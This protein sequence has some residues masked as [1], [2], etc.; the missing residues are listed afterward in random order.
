MRITVVGCGHVGLITGTCL[1]S[2]GHHVD[3]VDRD[4]YRIGQLQSGCLPLSEPHLEEIFQHSLAAGQIAFC[5]DMSEAFTQADIIFLCVGVPQL[6]NGESDFAALDSAAR[7]IAAAVH[8]PKLVVVRSTVPVQTTLQLQ[9]LLS[10]YHGISAI[11]FPVACNPQF[12]RQ[13][14]AVSGFFHPDRLLLGVEDAQSEKLLREIYRSIL[15]RRFTCPVHSGNCPASPPPELLV[16]KVRSAE[17]IKQTSNAYLAVKISYANVLADLCE[18]LGGNVAEVTHA[19]GLDPRIGSQFLSAGI[20]FGGS[21]L[22]KDLRAFCSL[23]ERLGVDAGIMRAAEEVNHGRIA[24]FFDKIE[25]SLWVLKGKRIAMLGLAHKPGTDDVRGSLALSLFKRLSSA[26]A[27]IR[28]FDPKA[29]PRA[30]LVYPDIV[31]V[32]DAYAAA[33]GADAL[34]ISTDWDEFRTL[35]WQRVHDT[36][37]RPVVFD[38]RNLLAPPQMRALGFEYHSVGRPG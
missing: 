37:A 32:E 28:V 13:G 11:P 31:C 34:V 20:G 25:R 36:M 26:G 18:R 22:P 21:K 7:E 16:T 33:L 35:V 1:A 19:V 15:E 8:E 23:A 3:C 14:T 38:G 5:T 27:S 24:D 4:A 17:L 10:V 9:H 30:R 12:L 2:L 29:M 6:E